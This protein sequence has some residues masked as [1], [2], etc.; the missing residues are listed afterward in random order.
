MPLPLTVSCFSKIQIGF[1]FLVLAH[2]GSPG[3]GP[4]NGCVCVCVLF[5]GFMFYI[6]YVPVMLAQS[7]AILLF[8]RTRAGAGIL[9]SV[10][11]VTCERNQQSDAN[12]RQSS[13][14]MQAADPTHIGTTA[15]SRR[16][17]T[18]HVLITGTHAD[19][20]H[21]PAGRT[22]YSD[23]GASDRPAMEQ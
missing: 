15:Q 12:Q 5:I 6:L 16:R 19:T 18:D 3:K 20:R 4:L 23:S 1:T 8:P 7:S 17:R 9:A 22:V 2:L 21:T 11:H 13:S 10:L 14:R